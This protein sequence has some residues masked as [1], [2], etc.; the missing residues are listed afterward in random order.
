MISGYEGYWQTVMSVGGTRMAQQESLPDESFTFMTDLS[1]TIT[2]VSPRVYHLL[3]Y[4][5][6]ELIGRPFFD[7]IAAGDIRRSAFVRD[8]LTGKTPFRCLFVSL[9]GMGG[10]IVDAEISGLPLAE[11]GHAWGCHGIVR[12]LPGPPPSG[13]VAC[14]QISQAELLLDLVC[15]DLN[16]MDQIEAGYLELAMGSLRPESKAYEYLTKCKTVLES[17]TRLIQNVQKLRQISTGTSTLEKVDLGRIL[18]ESVGQYEQARNQGVTIDFSPVCSCYVMANELLK[19]AFLN[20]IG[21]AIRHHPTG[22]PVI[23]VRVRETIDRQEK[24]CIVAIEDDGPGIPDDLKARLFNRFQQG[25]AATGGK[26][27]G[28]YLVKKLVEGFN[29]AVWVEDRVPGDY[30]KGSRFVIVLPA[31]D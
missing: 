9:A 26:G 4:T 15:H 7:I 1:G 19:D 3:G 28:L 30:R 22:S 29:G 23:V 6:A 16:N 21:N 25:P 31:A 13:D 11:T 14:S 5:P 18:A 20:V 12:R 2:I 10:R 27:L 24:R 17:N 8:A